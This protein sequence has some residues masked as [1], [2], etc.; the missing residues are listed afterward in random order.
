MSFY[1]RYLQIVY[2]TLNQN[3]VSGLYLLFLYIVNVER[4]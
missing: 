4:S 2:G 3:P 1:I